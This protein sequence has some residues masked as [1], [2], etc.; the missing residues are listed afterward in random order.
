MNSIS[1]RFDP[2][3]TKAAPVI[4]VMLPDHVA[5]ALAGPRPVQQSSLMM[6]GDAC[7]AT[8]GRGVIACPL[9]FGRSDALCV[10]EAL[11][12]AGFTGTLMVVAPPL[13]DPDMVERE[14]CAAAGDITPRFVSA[15]SA[16][17]LHSAAHWPHSPWQTAAA[18]PRRLH[19]VSAP[20]DRGCP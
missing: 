8:D 3:G 16:I 12:V 2:V 20:R 14:L 6:L 18:L 4:A 15:Q 5:L 10:I 1:D 11:L 9:I 7:L 17:R 19:P 13:A